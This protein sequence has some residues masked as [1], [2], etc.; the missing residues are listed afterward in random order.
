MRVTVT[1]SSEFR[2]RDVPEVESFN[3]TVE[4]E[5]ADSP[6]KVADTYLELRA[7]LNKAIKEDK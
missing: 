3:L 7:K 2:G 6:E 5:A 4:A 1:T